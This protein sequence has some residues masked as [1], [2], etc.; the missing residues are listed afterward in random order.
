MRAALAPAREKGET[1]FPRGRQARTPPAAQCPARRPNSAP[2]LFAP[3]LAFLR[4][5][6]AGARALHAAQVVRDGGQGR[7]EGAR[8]EIAIGARGGRV[9]WRF[10]S[11]SCRT[12]MPPIVSPLAPATPPAAAT[13]GPVPL[14][15]RRHAGGVACAPLNGGGALAAAQRAPLCGACLYACDCLRAAASMFEVEASEKNPQKKT[16]TGS[17]GL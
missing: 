7:R 11:F 15:A 8:G 17:G 10:P 14:P 1:R 16:L 5:G 6:A 4:A 13:A 2:A 3:P 12:Y 9:W